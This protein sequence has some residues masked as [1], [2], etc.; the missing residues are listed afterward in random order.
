MSTAVS[1]TGALAARTHRHGRVRARWSCSAPSGCRSAHP[2]HG[3][4]ADILPSVAIV[5]TEL[6]VSPPA[7]PHGRRRCVGCSA[8]HP[9]RHPG[10]PHDPGTGRAAFGDYWKLGLPVMVVFLAVAV[11][12]ASCR[13]SGDSE[14]VDHERA[15]PARTRHSRTTSPGFLSERMPR[16]VGCRSSRCASTRRTPPRHDARCHPVRVAGVLARHDERLS[17]C[18]RGSSLVI[19]RSRSRS[20]SPLPTRPT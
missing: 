14:P 10:E 7:V 6:Q 20:R 1:E 13:W 16:H 17:D 15:Q 9:R 19:T 12:G 2:Q 11:G 4:G 8:A 5:A 18:A 3:D